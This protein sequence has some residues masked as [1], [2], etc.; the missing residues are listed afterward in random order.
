MARRGFS[1][2]ELVVV[3]AVIA[4]TAAILF[5]VFAKAKAKAKEP[6]CASNLRQIGL[7]LEMYRGDSDSKYPLFLKDLVAA[8]PTVKP[9]LA[10]PADGTSGANAAETARTG[11]K[12]SVYYWS[13]YP[14]GLREALTEADPNHGVAFCVLHGQALPSMQGNAD[15]RLDTVGTVV[16]LRADG[17]VKNA[18][19]GMHCGPLSN[20]T[21]LQMRTE[22]SL[23][24]DTACQKHEFCDFAPN[25][26]KDWREQ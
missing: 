5:P 22:W 24:T 12:V 26:C 9:N 23:L 8:V 18:N 7:S 4:V 2:T 14:D 15:A 19:V 25:A 20:G 17:S 16:R 13:P 21:S 1:L 6:P 3:V 10:C 11:T